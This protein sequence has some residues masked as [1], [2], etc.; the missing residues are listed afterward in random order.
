MNDADDDLRPELYQEW[1]K[2]VKEGRGLD[3]SS[4]ELYTLSGHVLDTYTGIAYIQEDYSTTQ[5]SKWENGKL[6]CLD[7][8]ALVFWEGTVLY[9]INHVQYELDKF[10]EHP[11]TLRR[12]LE[13]ILEL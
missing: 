7:G 2:E 11:L 9:Y 5:L 6:H 10:Y 3:L 4:E 13:K 12:K 1:L 8:P